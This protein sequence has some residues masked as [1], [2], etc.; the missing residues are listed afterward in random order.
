MTARAPYRRPIGLLA[1][2]ASCLGSHRTRGAR[3]LISTPRGRCL[4]CPVTLGA[5]HL[6]S[7]P[8]GLHVKLP[9]HFPLSLPCPSA[10]KELYSLPLLAPCQVY[11]NPL[12]MLSW[13]GLVPGPFRGTSPPQKEINTGKLSRKGNP[14]HPHAKSQHTYNTTIYTHNMSSSYSMPP[15]RSG[16][17]GGRKGAKRGRP[18]TTAGRMQQDPTPLMTPEVVPDDAICMTHCPK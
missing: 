2:L 4:E 12:N 18:S 13:P 10:G 1:S 9:A 8:P 15:K 17:R 3:H 11:A 14:Q 6:I 16:A 5:R 7:P